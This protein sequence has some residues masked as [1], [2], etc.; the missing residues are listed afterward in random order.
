MNALAFINN[1]KK[2]TGYTFEVSINDTIKFNW[3]YDLTG[4]GSRS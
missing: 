1:L 3:K 4:S 2:Q